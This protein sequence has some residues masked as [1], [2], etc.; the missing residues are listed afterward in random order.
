VVQ[1]RSWVLITD[2]DNFGDQSVPDKGAREAFT[3]ALQQSRYVNVLPRARVY[4]TL[5]RM[6]QS[7]I[8]RIDETIG[9]EI[10]RRENVKVLLSG[11]IA[12]VDSTFQISVWATDPVHGNL[13]LAAN[14]RISDRGQFF[15][16]LDSL[17]RSVRNQLGESLSG[18][19]GSSQPLEKVTTN[20]WEALQLYSQAIDLMARGKPEQAPSLLQ[21][22]IARD[23][24]FAM[25]YLRLGDCYSSV[26][27]K[28]G[29][30]MVEMQ[31]AY[32]LRQTVSERERLWIEAQYHNM[33]ESYELAAQ[34]FA[35]L[36]SLY[37]DDAGAHEQL[38]LAHESLERLDLAITEQRRTLELN[39]NSLPGFAILILWLAQSNQNSEAIRTYQLASSRGMESPYLQWGLGMA[40]L[41]HDRIEDAR[42]QFQRMTHGSSVESELGQI[43]MAV[44]DLHE[45]KLSAAEA[46]LSVGLPQKSASRDSLSTT[47]R[48]LLGRIRLLTGDSEGGQRQ[49]MLILA[50]PPSDLQIIDVRLAG[51][52]LVDAGNRKLARQVLRRLA[53]IRQ[54]T[55]SGWN[56]A[57][58][59]S[60]EGEI[61]LAEGK[62]DQAL[63]A[64]HAAVGEF[65]D[66]VFHLALARA[67]ERRQDF[68]HASQEL[69][70]FLKTQGQIFQHGFPPDL[71]LAHLE[72]GRVYRRTNDLTRA[73]FQYEQF[74]A[75]WRQGDDLPVRHLAVHELQQLQSGSN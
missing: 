60:L 20:S 19:E 75:M 71:A 64:L 72:L 29:R 22:A 23:P 51:E 40:Y 18:I 15:E 55:P 11:S 4:E 9:R 34:S 7:D 74:L 50:M 73:R 12:R 17:A 30:A 62:I 16:M 66:P 68:V 2:F 3:I 47:R 38:A 14:T 70:Q 69:E 43:Y 28:N 65:P 63:A 32:D 59:H 46:K 33:Q 5:A 39:P 54:E 8:T 42:E 35:T 58:F 67:H 49:A 45:G 37:P 36:V 48:Y 41:G 25:A 13:L 53:T 31:H 26:I 56:N 21:G 57:S 61:L 24:N 10:C 27:G 52:L 1:P 6:K 44:A